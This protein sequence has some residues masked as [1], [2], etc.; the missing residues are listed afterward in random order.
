[1]ISF[2]R[3]ISTSVS[4]ESSRGSHLGGFTHAALMVLLLGLYPTPASAGLILQVANASAE[5]GGTGS[6]DVV[7]GATDGTFQVSG[8]SVELLVAAGSGVTLTGASVDTMTA[9]YVF[10]TLQSPPLTFATFPTT[11]FTASDSSMTSPGFVTLSGP[12]TETAGVEHVTFAVAAGTPGGAI[13]VS[14]VI[15]DNTQI[16]DVAGNILASTAANG[17]ITIN[18]SAVPEPSSLVIGSLSAALVGGAVALKRR[19]SGG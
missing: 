9:P 3:R 18:S 14:I 15:G 12:P 17:T 11:D 6:F 7:L 5:A 10:T 8:F 4:L 16:L 2:D 19:R 1:M 13:P